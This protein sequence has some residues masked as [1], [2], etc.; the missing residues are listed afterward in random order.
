MPGGTFRE[1]MHVKPGH[2]LLSDDHPGAKLRWNATKVH[3]VEETPE[4]SKPSV[5]APV[6]AEPEI[7]PVPAPEV[8][9]VTK[10]FEAVTVEPV[11]PI[12]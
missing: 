2:T 9:S 1:N 11:A 5:P 12:A 10:G 7:A 6:E 8:N 3:L 4:E